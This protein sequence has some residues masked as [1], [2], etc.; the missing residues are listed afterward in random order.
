MISSQSLSYL[1]YQK[2]KLYVVAI[3]TN[4]E[5]AKVF[6][7]N[8]EQHRYLNEYFIEIFN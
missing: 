7:N 4:G 8:Q 5:T 1:T 6:F 3:I 2:Q